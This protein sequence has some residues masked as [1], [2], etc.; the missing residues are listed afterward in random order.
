MNTGKSFANGNGECQVS[1]D[2]VPL[3]LRRNPELA[4]A[5]QFYYSS[6]T[7]QA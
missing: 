6:W 7:V 1:P 3:W 4:L 5:R 2:T